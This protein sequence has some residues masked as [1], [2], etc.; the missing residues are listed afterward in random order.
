ISISGI[1]TIFSLRSMSL[2]DS[3]AESSRPTQ[4]DPSQ[5][6]F[7]RRLQIFRQT[8]KNV[9]TRRKAIQAVRHR[10]IHQPIMDLSN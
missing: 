1:G 7:P 4:N 8:K 3:L 5:S 6:H 9:V 10:S 2:A